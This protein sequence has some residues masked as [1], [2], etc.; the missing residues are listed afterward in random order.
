MWETSTRAVR[1]QFTKSPI[2][3]LPNRIHAGDF[4]L[5]ALSEKN[6]SG[7]TL[8]T[9]ETRKLGRVNFHKDFLDCCLGQGKKLANSSK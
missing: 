3:R 9:V 1:T 5:Q 6:E 7:V 8:A 4:V 2:H